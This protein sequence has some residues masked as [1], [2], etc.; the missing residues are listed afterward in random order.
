MTS[1]V[2]EMQ[3][4]L[5]NLQE[6]ESRVETLK[7]FEREGGQFRMG[8]TIEHSDYHVRE[9]VERTWNEFVSKPAVLRWLVE[10]ASKDLAKRKEE[11]LA[12]AMAHGISQEVQP[13]EPRP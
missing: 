12:C 6:A 13:R 9:T 8:L 10:H 7:K 4:L 5:Y 11:F 3:A 1:I 2:Q